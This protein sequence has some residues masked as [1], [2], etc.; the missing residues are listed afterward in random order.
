MQKIEGDREG[1]PQPVSRPFKPPRLE[2]KIPYPVLED[3]MSH[4]G[5]QD[6]LL[7][8]LDKYTRECLSNE[9]TP[10]PLKMLNMCSFGDAT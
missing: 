4:L 7:I 1:A 9:L 5:N 3:T 10:N 6:N 2:R 8:N